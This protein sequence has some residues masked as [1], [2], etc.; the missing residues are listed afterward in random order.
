MKINPFR[1]KFGQLSK[2]YPAFRLMMYRHMSSGI[3]SAKVIGE[4]VLS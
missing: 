3:K 1:N 4:P 2:N